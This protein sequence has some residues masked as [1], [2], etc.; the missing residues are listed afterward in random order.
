MKVFKNS[1]ISSNNGN[2]RNYGK[3]FKFD[4]N[5][6]IN[7]N[8]KYHK[9]S[10]INKILNY[11]KN[12][13]GNKI[14]NYN[15]NGNNNKILI[16]E[17]NENKN[18]ILNL[19]KKADTNSNRSIIVNK[20]NNQFRDLSVNN[21]YK[22]LK[23][24]PRKIYL[25]KK[26]KDLLLKSNPTIIK[27]SFLRSRSTS[28]SEKILYKPKKFLLQ[29]S[30][31]LNR[32]YIYKTDGKNDKKKQ[33][34]SFHQNIQKNEY[35]NNNI[36][37]NDYENSKKIDFKNIHKNLHKRVHKNNNYKNI[38]NNIQKIDYK[39]DY[40]N[41]SIH[42]QSFNNKSKVSN[43]LIDKNSYIPSR[44]SYGHVR[45]SFLDDKNEIK[46]HWINYYKKEDAKKQ[47]FSIIYGKNNVTSPGGKYPIIYKKN[48]KQRTSYINIQ[49]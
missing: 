8:L 12:E 19:K 23:K 3:S 15:H 9:S 14:L 46:N 43:S 29:K 47:N 21:K 18:K 34:L 24:E 41:N 25:P 28:Q 13:N 37:K 30:K 35:K 49:K 40:M 42:S 6:N 22:N 36:Q 38:L 39:N 31:N 44:E 16:L 26:K 45:E 27:N 17:K 33:L 2:L 48:Y 11:H 7:Q 5:K 4:S 10:D 20:K 1:D 32:T